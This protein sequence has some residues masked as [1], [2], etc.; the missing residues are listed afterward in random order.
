MTQS[1]ADDQWRLLRARAIEDGIFAFNGEYHSE[2]D[3]PD[4]VV[5]FVKRTV[6]WT[7]HHKSIMNLSLYMQRIERS[8]D[9]RAC[10]SVAG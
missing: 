2:T 4:E 10:V 9:S 1:I 8:I 6:A 7:N 5:P 3:V